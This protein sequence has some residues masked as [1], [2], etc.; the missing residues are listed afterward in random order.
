MS[1]ALTSPPHDTLL[2]RVQAVVPLV[3]KN[4]EETER[5][6]RPVDE[7]IGALAETGIFRSFVPKRFGGYEIDADEFISLGLAVAEACT[8]TGW[9]TTFY[10][11]HN[12]M[13]SQFPPETQEE[14]FGQQPFILAPA[15]ITPS[16][17]V[18]PRD[19]GYRLSG[20]WAWGTGVIHADW[21]LLN[22]VIPGDTPDVRLFLVPRDE[23][24]IDDE[25]DAVGMAGTGS[26]DMIAEDVFVPENRSEN[27]LDIAAGRGSGARWHDSACYR[28]PMLPLLTIAAAI[29][30]LGAAHRAVDVFKTQLE[31]RILYAT[32]GKQAERAS[33]Q[34]RLAHSVVRVDAAETLLRSVAQRLT[35]WGNRDDLC[36]PEERAHLRLLSGHVVEICR[37]VV[38]EITQSSGASAQRRRHPIQ[39]LHRDIHTIACHT[40]FDLD[41]GAENY[42]RILLGRDPIAP[43]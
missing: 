20:R 11:E 13:F 6:R 37:D 34:M 16:G 4:A 23:I 32:M 24:Q 15:S 10:M 35:E 29:P 43:T 42:G 14:V 38:R 1:K 31:E 33:A 21:V 40:A 9:V 19:G 22:G 8:S 12:W 17:Q 36:P 25:W 30:A 5:L 3:A 2:E 7:V 39:R 28:I 41:L 18:T 27:L 26:H